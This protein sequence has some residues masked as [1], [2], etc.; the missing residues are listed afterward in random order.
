MVRARQEQGEPVPTQPNGQTGN[1]NGDDTV[2]AQ[3]QDPNEQGAGGKPAD[4]VPGEPAD[5]ADATPGQTAPTNAGA[6]A[7]GENPKPD[8]TSTALGKSDAPITGD[9]GVPAPAAKYI[10]EDKVSG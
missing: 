4:P 10:R 5:N 3:R 8:S 1:P 9:A 6:P 2:F 7:D